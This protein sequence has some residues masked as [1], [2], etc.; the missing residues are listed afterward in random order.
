LP[1]PP[2]PFICPSFLL[3]HVETFPLLRSC[4]CL[5]FPTLFPSPASFSLL[6]FCRPTSSPRILATAN[7]G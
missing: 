2:I 6:L 1:V 7:D 5:F 4:L 3:F